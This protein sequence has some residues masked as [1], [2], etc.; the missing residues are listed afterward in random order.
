M[1][2]SQISF[3]HLYYITPNNQL[4]YQDLNLTLI[5][6]K[7]ALIGVNGIGKTT[8][9]KIITHAIQPTLG[10]V[11]VRD[12]LSYLP[13]DLVYY[14]SQTIAQLFGIEQKLQALKNIFEGS[15]NEKN[16]EVIGEDW[17]IERTVAQ[18]LEKLVLRNIELTAPFTNYSG[19][20][21]N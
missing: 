5:M 8:L 3:K 6:R 19:G 13:Q 1:S 4:L 18:Q 7:A 12:E 11:I 17:H 21:D 14:Q 20:G 15:I 2:D 16:F 10:E 9:L